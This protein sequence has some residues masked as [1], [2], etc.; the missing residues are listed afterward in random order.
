MRL[1]SGMVEVMIL[2]LSLA[3]CALFFVVTRLLKNLKVFMERTVLLSA[4]VSDIR[5]DLSA[6][7]Q[8]IERIRKGG[9]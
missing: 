9:G 4:D 6:A 1:R 2:G 3:I 5:R 7:M 8:T